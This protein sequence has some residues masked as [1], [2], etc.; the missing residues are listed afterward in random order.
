MQFISIV[1]I[2]KRIIYKVQGLIYKND[3]YY[4]NGNETLPPPLS[5]EDEE[6]MIK[7]IDSE[8]ARN[9]LIEHNLRLV[10]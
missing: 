2:V 6:D 5:A 4:I 10:A 7:N 8:Y 9:V 1:R 3:V